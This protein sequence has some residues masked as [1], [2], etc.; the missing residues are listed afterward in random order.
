MVVEPVS[1]V[2]GG[3]YVFIARRDLWSRAA[4]RKKAQQLRA[5]DT[6]PSVAAEVGADDWIRDPDRDWS[7]GGK[8]GGARCACV[9]RGQGG[10]RGEVRGR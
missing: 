3:I 2:G 5:P 9:S 10:A 4:R 6:E 7:G 1:D 8:W